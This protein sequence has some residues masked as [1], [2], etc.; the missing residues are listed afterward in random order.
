VWHARRLLLTCIC[1]IVVSFHSF[2]PADPLAV[3]TSG[4]H[5]M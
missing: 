2:V 1:F 5:R 4:H 3:T